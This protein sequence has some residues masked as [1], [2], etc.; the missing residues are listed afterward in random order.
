MIVEDL[1][2]GDISNW[3]GSKCT[4]LLGARASLFREANLEVRGKDWRGYRV[5]VVKEFT[6]RQSVN[7]TA[8]VIF[9]VNRRSINDIV[10]HWQDCARTKVKSL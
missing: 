7:R 8:P 1:A 6:G 3:T 4:I 2:V 5:V 9:F 10:T